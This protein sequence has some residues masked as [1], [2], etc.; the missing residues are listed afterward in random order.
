MRLSEAKRPKPQILNFMLNY[1]NCSFLF[2]FSYAQGPKP[3]S[4]VVEFYFYKVYHRLAVKNHR[5]ICC[6]SN[7]TNNTV[8]LL[9][10][11]RF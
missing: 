3:P 7:Y 5:F 4:S 11:I 9:L 8:I 1:G 2:I 10:R 6:L